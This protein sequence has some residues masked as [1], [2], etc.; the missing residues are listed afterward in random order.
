ML[1]GC[2]VRQGPADCKLGHLRFDSELLQ[3]SRRPAGRQLHQLGLEPELVQ[4][5]STGDREGSRSR[6]GERALSWVRGRVVTCSERL[7]L[8]RLP[9][10]L[11]SDGDDD[12][13]LCRKWVTPSL[14]V[15]FPLLRAQMP[16]NQLNRLIDWL[17]PSANISV[18]S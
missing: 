10:R 4:G 11:Q 5:E 16:T 9:R 13:L 1:G 6:T 7:P 14:P 17:P 18:I 3:L 8:A 2:T 12:T 15:G